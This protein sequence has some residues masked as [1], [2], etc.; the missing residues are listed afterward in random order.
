MIIDHRTY[1]LHPGKLPQLLKLY[2]EKGYAVQTRHLGKPVGWY[3]SMDI[4]QLNQIVHMWAYDDLNQRAARR[5]AMQADPEWAAYLA[6]ATP[7]LQ[8]M[9]NKI[10]T[11]AP[12][13]ED[14]PAVP[15]AG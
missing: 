4:G 15:E 8:R 3:V 14:P 9:E 5:A 6:E 2:Q 10:L 11:A 12:F 1:T 13:F 7:L